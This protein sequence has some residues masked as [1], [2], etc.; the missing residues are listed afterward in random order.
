MSIDLSTPNKARKALADIVSEQKRLKALNRDLNENIEKKTADLSKISK[1]LSEL[2]AGGGYTGERG[3]GSLDKYVRRD[4]TVRIRGE[5]TDDHAYMPGLM[6]DAP[7]TDWQN[8]AQKALTDYNMVRAIRRNGEAPKAK[9]RLD[10]ILSRAPNPSVRKAFVDVDGS[11]GDWIPSVMLPQL[12]RDLTMERRLASL[13]EVV[14]MADKTVILPYLSTGFRPYKKIASGG[15]DVAQFTSSSMSTDQRTI[16]ASG[17]A[18]RAQ[19]D[20]DASEDSIL[21]AMP[22]ISQEIVQ[23]LRDAEED[24]LLN[25]NTETSGDVDALASWNIRGR[26]GASGLG[27]A[28][29]HRKTY[30]GLRHRAFDLSTDVAA[31]ADLAGVL[32]LRSALDA[33][34]GVDGDLILIA[35]PE[36]YL[37]HL[38]GLSEAKTLEQWGPNFTALSGQISQISGCPIILSEFV[39]GDLNASGLYDGSTTNKTSVILCNRSRFKLGVRSG[40]SVEISKDITRSVFDVVAQSRSVF[41][42]VDSAS[43]KNVS[44]AYNWSI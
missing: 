15:D 27:T 29:D 12:E 11:G 7:V 18:V 23:S 17:M 14:P 8:D 2:E 1:R 24:C 35:S 34:H 20:A 32:S 41:Y 22:I 36:A 31:T 38:V 28:S 26:W 40:A 16:T 9:A 33:P 43:K 4:G 21:A 25:G 10:E 42:S 39:G 13:F 3:D 6:D 30:M 37:K 44:L 5:A 19:V